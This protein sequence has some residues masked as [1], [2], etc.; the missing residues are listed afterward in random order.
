MIY[1]RRS[2][3]I[4]NGNIL[5]DPVQLVYKNIRNYV[6]CNIPCY[7]SEQYETEALN[8]CKVRKRIRK[9]FYKL[10]DNAE[11]ARK[12]N[13]AMKTTRHDNTIQSFFAGA[14]F[15]QGEQNVR[16]INCLRSR[17]V[18]MYPVIPSIRFGGHESKSRCILY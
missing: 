11:S 18:A 6:L 4:C 12:Y 16:S 9:Y 5:I 17:A 2:G 1:C 8:G 14:S 13:S 3:D 10:I 15:I 7:L